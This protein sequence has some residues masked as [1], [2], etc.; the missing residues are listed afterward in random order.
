MCFCGMLTLPWAKTNDSW[1]LSLSTKDFT[2]NL[3]DWWIKR[4][5]G[6]RSR[7]DPQPAGGEVGRGAVSRMQVDVRAEA[8][9]VLPPV[10]M[11]DED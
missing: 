8:K 3:V 9:G 10:L 1:P 2:V 5:C 4:V 7:G 6:A 11:M